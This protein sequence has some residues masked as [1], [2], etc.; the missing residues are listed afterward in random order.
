MSQYS[1]EYDTSYDPPL[2]VV[3]I[4]LKDLGSDARSDPLIAIVDSGADACL[5][6]IRL[7]HE[8]NLL[9]VRRAT[10]RGISGESV[11][12]E[13]FLL[14]VEIGSITIPGVRVIGDRHGH[15]LIIGRD[16]LNQWIVTL[17]GLAGVVDVTA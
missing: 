17:N 6:P 4:F 9:P 10:M 5:I 14:S 8:L 12:V 3:E 13:V 2:P 15:E 7:L 16:V 11:P 1:H